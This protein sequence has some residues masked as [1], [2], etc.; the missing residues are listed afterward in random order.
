[1][2]NGNGKGSGSDTEDTMDV[3]Q[4]ADVLQSARDRAEHQL[5]VNRP[6]VFLSW[7]VI[8]LVVYG[9]IWLSVRNQRPFTGPTSAALGFVTIFVTVALIITVAALS[10]VSEGVGGRS[11]LQRRFS[12]VSVPVALAGVF[13]LEAALDHAGASREVLA[14]YGAAAPILVMGVVYLVSSAI[15]LSW[16]MAAFGAW[17]VLAAAGSGFAGPVTVW[18]VAGLAVGAGFLVMAAYWFRQ[19]RS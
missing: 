1:M 4:A 14:T 7:G 19:S 18:P 5:T 10:R 11:A 12:S 6:V 3:T 8:Y 17:M 9:V 2:S 16:S 13:F 15:S